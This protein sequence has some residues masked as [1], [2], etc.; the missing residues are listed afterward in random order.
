MLAS[1]SHPNIAAIYGVDDSAGFP[2]LVLELV[3]GETIAD[4]LARG[5]IPVAEAL[6]Y[7]RQ[8]ADALDTAHEAGIVHR[9]LKPGNIK[10]TDDGRIKVLDFGLAKAIAAATA[11]DPAADPAHSPTVTIH[12]TKG[13]V[14]LGTAAYMSPEQARG[15]AIDKRTDIWAFGC[16]LYEMLTGGRVFGGETTSDVIAAIIERAPDLSKL[17]PTTPPHVRRVILR[18]LEKDPKRRARDI[19]DVRAEIDAPHEAAGPSPR[20]LA[21][22]WIVGAAVAA[23][24]A[25]LLIMRPAAPAGSEPLLVQST[26]PL[27]NGYRLAVGSGEYPLAISRD[28]TRIAFAG[29]QFG[30]RRL[31]VRSLADRSARVL[32]G[33]EGAVHPFFSP[34]G[35]WVGYFAADSAQKVAFGGGAPIRL[36]T[37]DGQTVGGTWGD[38]VIVLAQRGRG[39]SRLNASGGVAT[40]IEG[41]SP[42]SWP[43]MLDDGRTLLFVTA[44]GGGAA[45]A[46]IDVDGTKKRIIASTSE[47]GEG[48]T[49]LGTGGNLG[50]VQLSGRFLVYGQG[51][52]VV[53]ALPIDPATMT[54]VGSVLSLVSG[55]E[56]ARNGG[57]LYFAVSRNGTMIYASTGDQ[58]SL[59]WVDRNGVETP[60]TAERQAYRLPRIS[61]DGA[62]VVV[63]INDD[64]R[65][66]NLW[67]Y[68]SQGQKIRLTTEGHSLSPLW[69]P[70][71]SRVALGAGGIQEVTIRDLS[72]RTLF[73]RPTAAEWP[74]GTNPYSTSWSPDG[75]TILIQADDR[76]LWAGS[77]EDGR[78]RP[79]LARAANDS[80]GQFSPDGRWIAYQSDEFGRV[81]VSVRRYPSME[82]VT[83]VSLN[84]GELPRWSA[85][86]KE[87][88]YKQGNALM[89][90]RV[91]LD[92]RPRVLSRQRLFTGDYLGAGREGAFDVTRD[93]RRFVMI[94]SDPASA[95]NA[96]TLVQNWTGLLNRPPQD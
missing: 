60:L 5:S 93:G 77:I 58:H 4:R 16:V 24:L 46:T 32:P 80:M 20:R 15:K 84:G 92:P 31:F 67:M 34:D 14:I 42:G 74:V 91:E 61:P 29:E 96:L 13:G 2:A 70:D 1:L 83:V 56:R 88:F 82:D 18:C 65:R 78:V 6:A 8:I 35:E 36:G 28:G 86:A 47:Y 19:A 51:A 53:R 71:G 90:A 62:R 89:A 68:D 37:I 44:R 9:D 94:K 69:S 59:V 43:S 73:E 57:G 87:I 11:P 81:E 30:D 79:L 64:T 63:A 45:I 72:R 50:Q 10:I 75:R 95:L 22:G 27:P 76:D 7:A 17:P 55:L 21:V 38:G 48:P 25:G 49:L 12:G 40:R 23:S 52:D 66:S 26:L 3:D 85:D 33:T 39:L 41:G 54:P